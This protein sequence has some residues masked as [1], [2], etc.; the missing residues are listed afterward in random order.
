MA[1]ATSLYV[2]LSLI[3]ALWAVVR[4]NLLQTVTTFLLLKFV[5]P[6]S[7]EPLFVSFMLHAVSFELRTFEHA[8]TIGKA[9]KNYGAERRVLHGPR[10]IFAVAWI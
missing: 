5:D 2:R 7:H 6:L 4:G 1:P 8:T 9:C 10:L 3:I